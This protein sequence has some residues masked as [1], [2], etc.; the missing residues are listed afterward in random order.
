[1][2]TPSSYDLYYK[3]WRIISN[4]DDGNYSTKRYDDMKCDSESDTINEDGIDIYVIKNIFIGGSTTD[5][6]YDL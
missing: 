3:P 5:S 1:M 4:I 6:V 2:M